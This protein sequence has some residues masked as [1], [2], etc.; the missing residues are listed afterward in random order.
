MIRFGYWT[1]ID[2]TMSKFM[3]MPKLKIWKPHITPFTGRA[4]IWILLVRRK[5]FSDNSIYN[6]SVT[7]RQDKKCVRDPIRPYSNWFVKLYEKIY[8]DRLLKAE[9]AISKMWI[10]SLNLILQTMAK[11]SNWWFFLLNLLKVFQ[12]C[13]RVLH[14]KLYKARQL[15]RRCRGLRN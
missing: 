15:T 12:K 13:E 6:L 3:P 8:S 7:A 4:H 1:R 10:R 5:I 2:G 14:R 11:Y 9:F